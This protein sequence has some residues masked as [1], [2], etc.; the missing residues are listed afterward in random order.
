MMVGAQ[1]MMA[2]PESHRDPEALTHLISKYQITTLHFVPSMLAAFVSYLEQTNA[3]E[4]C[5]SL[6]RVFCSGEALSRELADQ[7]ASLINA[8]LHNLYGP[9]EAA[10]DVTYK[11]AAA[12]DAG[13]ELASSVPIG[14]PVWNTQL[15]VLD[16]ALRAVPV[17]VAGE[18]Y[19]C[20]VQ[21]ADG[22]LGKPA[23]TATRFVADPYA[24]GQRMYRTGD[25]VRW[26]P[27]GDVEYLGR[28]DDQL[29]IRGQRI[30][31]G[32]IEAAMLAL[33]GV[34]QA[35]VHAR[36]LGGVATQAGMDSRQLVGYVVAANVAQSEALDPVQLRQLLSDKLPV[37]MVPVAIVAVPSFP[38]RQPVHQW[39]RCLVPLVL[40]AAYPQTSCTSSR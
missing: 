19:L 12:V 11:P 30:E 13:T 7:Y 17:G 21:L 29:K 28:S 1:L 22:Y 31:L 16:A 35:A 2:P 34:A 26:L 9:T 36:V 14:V 25:V 18:L 24:D 37:H 15:R 40:K 5:R 32:E 3:A 33:P 23:M 4:I 6:C 27:T 38:L 39:R 10:V 20:G 8:P